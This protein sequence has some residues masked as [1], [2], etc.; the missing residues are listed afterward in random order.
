MLKKYSAL[1]F[2]F[3]L[4]VVFSQVYRFE[5]DLKV[6]GD[7]VSNDSKTFHAALEITP[8]EK[9]FFDLDEYKNDS[10]KGSN[11]RISYGFDQRLMK[12]KKDPFNLNLY[13]INGNYFSLKTEDKMSWKIESET[14]KISNYT[15]QKATTDFGGRLWTAWFTKEIPVNEGP[16]KFVGLPGMILEINDSKNHYSYTLTKIVKL[17]KSSETKNILETE[18][19]VKAFPITIAQYKKLYLDYYTDPFLYLKNRGTFPINFNGTTYSKYEELFPLRANIQEKIRKYHNP[20]EESL[21]VNY[22]KN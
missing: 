14:K 11:N 4:N 1:I 12:N 13:K 10:I 5:Y 16:Y 15:V 22:H 17:E 3:I 6:V 7:T 8:E 20:I 18:Y 9:K 21:K 2:L 19:G